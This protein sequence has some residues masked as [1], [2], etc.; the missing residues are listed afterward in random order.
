MYGSGI[1]ISVD[2][3]ERNRD[4]RMRVVNS[5]RGKESVNTGEQA[6]YEENDSTRVVGRHG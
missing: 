1:G 3:D 5:S 6:G 4:Q 2:I